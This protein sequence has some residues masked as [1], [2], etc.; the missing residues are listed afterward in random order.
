[1]A[2]GNC[3]GLIAPCYCYTRSPCIGTPSQAPGT[4]PS[5]SDCKF[6]NIV[7]GLSSIGITWFAA[8]TKGVSSPVQ[9]PQS[10]AGIAASL[11]NYLPIILVGGLAL[12]AL[13]ILKRE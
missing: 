4:N 7:Q 1:M 2:N 12:F 10:K 11:T 8:A 5:T 13:L 9:T 3:C 6:S